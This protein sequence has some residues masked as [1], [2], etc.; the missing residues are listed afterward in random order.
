MFAPGVP[1]ILSSLRGLAYFEINVRGASTDLH[2]GSYGGAV[3]NP[4]QALAKIVASLHDETGRVAI[5]GFYDR[6]REWPA[7]VRE[8][9][10]GLPFDEERYREE[11]G[12]P[13]LGGEAG[14]TVL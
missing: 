13:A 6:V 5:P 8:Q 9:M 4:A 7:R 2:S 14:Y 12:V 3:P 10:R 1:T 11:T